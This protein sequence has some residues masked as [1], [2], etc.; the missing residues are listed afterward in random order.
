MWF[1]SKFTHFCLGAYAVSLRNS[2]RHWFRC[3]QNIQCV[4]RKRMSLNYGG[5]FSTLLCVKLALA[6]PRQSTKRCIVGL[7]SCRPVA[8]DNTPKC[9]TALYRAVVLSLKRHAKRRI[10]VR[11]LVVMSLS[12]LAYKPILQFEPSANVTS[13]HHAA[14]QR[15]ICVPR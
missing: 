9:Q 7:S 1:Y 12:H 8:S 4:W 13:Q 5:W 3:A 10:V 2:F 15:A 14:R 11:C 6:R